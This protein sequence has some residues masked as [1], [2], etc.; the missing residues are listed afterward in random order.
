M[1]PEARGLDYYLLPDLFRDSLTD[2][3]YNNLIIERDAWFAKNPKYG[4]AYLQQMEKLKAAGVE[5][6]PT[7]PREGLN[8]RDEYLPD[9]VGS[10]KVGA[11]RRANAADQ[12]ARMGLPKMSVGDLGAIASSIGGGQGTQD[13]LD[14]LSKGGESR[15][16]GW[17]GSG[18]TKYT[19]AREEDEYDTDEEE[20]GGQHSRRR[21]RVDTESIPVIKEEEDGT[22]KKVV[23]EKAK[24]ESV[25][26]E[27]VR[28]E[29]EPKLEDVKPK[30]ED[31]KAVFCV[32]ARPRLAGARPRPRFSVDKEH[33]RA[34]AM[35]S[36]DPDVF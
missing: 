20:S 1:V 9:E 8:S 28:C 32:E 29:I 26:V 6:I 2:D 11:G 10:G 22:V 33:L 23:R 3:G 31:I 21:R 18:Y 27:S 13:I 15:P 24:H 5:M 16:N 25:K 34:L 12:V 17:T 36:H 7:N 35:V 30:I 4:N 14:L 19:R